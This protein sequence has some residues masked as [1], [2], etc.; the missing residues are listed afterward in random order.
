M[1]HAVEI[2]DRRS[3][4]FLCASDLKAF[5]IEP[6][7]EAALFQKTFL[8]LSK[9]LIKQVV[10]LVDQANQCVGCCFRGFSFDMGPIGRIGPILT[11]R[12]L[13]H[14]PRPR[15]LLS[16]KQ[17][18]VLT[19]KILAIRIFWGVPFRRPPDALSQPHPLRSGYAHFE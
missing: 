5:V 1:S 10:R 3:L 11:M 16:P 18:P 8:Q 7:G 6:F 14:S 17:Q 4:S 12:E 15:V 2:G 9:L 19:Q 13:P